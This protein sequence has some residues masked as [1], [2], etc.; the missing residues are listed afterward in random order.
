MTKPN[1]VHIE[2]PVTIA[3]L[4]DRLDALHRL[5]EERLPAASQRELL[6]VEQ[7]ALLVHRSPQ[8]IRHRCRRR[9][10]GTKVRGQWFIDRASLLAKP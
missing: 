10:I 5:I 7:A 2:R 1:V 8:A 6:T 9:L 3:D 4:A